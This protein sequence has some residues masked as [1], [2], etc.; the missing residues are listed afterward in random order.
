MISLDPFE[1]ICG[2]RILGSWGGDCRPDSD[3]PR[4]GELY[5]QGKLPLQRLIGRRYRLEDINLALDDLEARRTIRPLIEIDP[6]LG[7]AKR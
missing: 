1:L 6:T 5:R 4:F 2:K 3:L 7:A